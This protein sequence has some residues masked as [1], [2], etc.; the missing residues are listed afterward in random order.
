MVSKKIKKVIAVDLADKMIERAKNYIFLGSA[1][2]PNIFMNFIKNG[3]LHKDD[4]QSKE[5]WER[6]GKRDVYMTMDEIRTLADKHIPNAKI[7]RKL[8]W[9][10]LLVWEK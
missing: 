8:F 9:R 2:V 7:K 4:A 1:F 5:V 6:H 10:Y 3:K